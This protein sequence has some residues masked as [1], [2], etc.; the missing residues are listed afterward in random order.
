MPPHVPEVIYVS[1]NALNQNGIEGHIIV[2]NGVKYI[3]YVE[4]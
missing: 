3:F 2:I 4:Q 1:E